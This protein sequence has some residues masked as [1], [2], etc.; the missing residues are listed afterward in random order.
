MS[1]KLFIH[2]PNIHVGG[3]KAL[4]LALLNTLPKDVALVLVMDDRLLLTKELPGIFRRVKPSIIGRFKA[5]MWLASEVGS[6]DIVLCFGNLPPLFKL[7]GHVIVFVQN[8]Y[9]VDTPSLSGFPVRTRMRLR[10]ERIWLSRFM[11]N[12]DELIVQSPSMKSLLASWV[13]SK[14]VKILPFMLDNKG[15]GRG[16]C[17]TEA[18]DSREFDFLY[19][20]SGEP[21]KNHRQLVEAWCRLAK[22]NYFP[23]L[24]LTLNP[25]Q[26]PALCELI[27]QKTE[28]HHLKIVNMGSLNHDQIIPLYDRASALIYPSTLESFGVPMIE[29]RQA[30]LPVLA[31]E[32]DFVRDV[33][34]PVESFDPNSSISMA[35]AVKRFMGLNESA[36]PLVDA[37]AFLAQV[38]E[39]ESR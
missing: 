12:A 30:G 13:K 38:L 10:V 6:N 17:Q 37:N 20:A 11:R 31:S 23:S 33:L 9:L 2:A 36:L 18:R 1:A 25:L 28:Q 14:P 34:D 24:V 7:R 26:W 8:R 4:L 19:V 3:G 5:E 39:H 22:E 16:G 15:Y 27:N 21:H 29:A 35:R 32:L